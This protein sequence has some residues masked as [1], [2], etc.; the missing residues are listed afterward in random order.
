MLKILA[1]DKNKPV[2]ESIK[3]CNKVLIISLK[4]ET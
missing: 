3:L 2:L 4:V 1:P